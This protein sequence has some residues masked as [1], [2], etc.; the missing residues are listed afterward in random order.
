M[1]SASELRQVEQLPGQRVNTEAR[2][3]W[4][5]RTCAT[6]DDSLRRDQD[7]FC[8]V[9][10]TP[11][12]TL[13]VR[14]CGRGFVRSEK[15]RAGFMRKALLAR[16]NGALIAARIYPPRTRGSVRPHQPALELAQRKRERPAS[17]DWPL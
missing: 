7:L 11:R 14:A 3:Q 6:D 13:R 5:S 15:R 8:F 4:S 9:G 2:P 17:G 1:R 16:G 12:R 10:S